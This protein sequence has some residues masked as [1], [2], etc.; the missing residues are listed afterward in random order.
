[1]QLTQIN[2]TAISDFNYVG[3]NEQKSKIAE[4]NISEEIRKS[5]V[6]SVNLEPSKS[7]LSDMLAVNIE[8]I[9]N[10]NV[11]QKNISTQLDISNEISTLI[12]NAQKSSNAIESLDVVQPQ[13]QNLMINYNEISKSSSSIQTPS[14]EEK[15]RI[16]FDGILGSKPLST[17]EIF[18]EINKQ[19]QILSQ[20]QQNLRD[21]GKVAVEDSRNIINQ[22]RMVSQKNSPFKDNDYSKDG[23]GLKLQTLDKITDVQIGASSSTSM[24]LLS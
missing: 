17:S 16:F 22:E 12:S 19:Q 8:K 23:A 24:K 6:I 4:A 13:V 11:V 9:S 3:S 20:S 10:I 7:N 1:M 2:N 21:E 18:K 14:Q 15:S 5:D